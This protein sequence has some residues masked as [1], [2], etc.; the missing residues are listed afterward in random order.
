M[1]A[2]RRSACGGA[3]PPHRAC[4]AAALPQAATA[5]ADAAPWEVAR[6]RAVAR[7]GV[8]RGHASAAEKACGARPATTALQWLLGRK[9]APCRR[10]ALVAHGVS[11]QPR[12]PGW[13]LRVA[14]ATSPCVVAK[15]PI[16]AAVPLAAVK[17]ALA[18][19]RPL[20]SAVVTARAGWPLAFRVVQPGGLKAAR[21]RSRG[22]T[23]GAVKSGRCHRQPCVGAR[24]A[25]HHCHPRPHQHSTCRCPAARPDGVPS[26]ADAQSGPRCP[27]GSPQGWAAATCPCGPPGAPG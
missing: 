25:R 14:E 1:R 10:Q 17:P 12:Q 27:G 13:P 20:Q 5:P 3:C 23:P 8:H 4:G 21:P 18:A 24:H 7:Q 22:R 6:P 26:L 9:V 19:A 16:A 15:P 2:A 11:P